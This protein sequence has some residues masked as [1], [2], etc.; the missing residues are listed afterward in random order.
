MEP[1]IIHLPER[2]YHMPEPC[3]LER[4]RKVDA[5]I[6]RL[7]VQNLA[8]PAGREVGEKRRRGAKVGLVE[9]VPDRKR[10][11]LPILEKQAT[12]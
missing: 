7:I 12:L 4:T 5:L 6:D 3:Q 9:K 1:C 2:A 10:V 11:I 8:S